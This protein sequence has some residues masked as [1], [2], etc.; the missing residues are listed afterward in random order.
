MTQASTSDRLISAASCVVAAPRGD[1]ER[2]V[3]G[4]GSEMV[5]AT[6]AGDFEG[7]AQRSIGLVE[8]AT[9]AQRRPEGE[10]GL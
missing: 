3:E 1:V 6:P 7:F 5:V 8:G 2:P 4:T 10:Q 9:V